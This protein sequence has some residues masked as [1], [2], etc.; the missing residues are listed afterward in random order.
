[1]PQ[2]DD[3]VTLAHQ[4]PA[5]YLAAV[6]DSAA[7]A[8]RMFRWSLAIAGLLALCYPAAWVAIVLLYGSSR[9]VGQGFYLVWL[10]LLLLPFFVVSV[11]IAAI[12]RVRMNAASKTAQAAE[13]WV[14]VRRPTEY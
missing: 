12:S 11:V 14:A 2:L 6:R 5:A 1:L 10:W 9:D 7:R 3:L 4:N 8:R 13:A